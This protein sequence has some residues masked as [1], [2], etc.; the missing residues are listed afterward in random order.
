MLRHRR[1]PRPLGFPIAQPFPHSHDPR[2][3]L[4]WILDLFGPLSHRVLEPRLRYLQETH[5]NPLQM[6]TRVSL[7]IFFQGRSVVCR[8]TDPEGMGSE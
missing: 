1:A 7:D 3:V 6:A 2:A 4:G 5:Q 8:K